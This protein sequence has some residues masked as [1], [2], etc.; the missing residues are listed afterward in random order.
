M[1]A[2]LPQ[3]APVHSHLYRTPVFGAEFDLLLACVHSFDKQIRDAIEQAITRNVNWDLFAHM[4]GHHG[5]LPSVFQQLLAHSTDVPKSALESFKRLHQINS[6]KTLWLTSELLRVAEQFEQHG[7]NFLAYKG[8]TLGQFL[9]GDVTERQFGDLDLLVHPSDV[10]RAISLVRELG[11]RSNLALNPAQAKA[12]LSIGY[13]YSFDSDF[14]RN[15]LEIKWQ[16]LPCFYAI[17]FDVDKLFLRAT[18]IKISEQE[19]PTLGPEDLLLVLCVH[20]A[21][22][23][24]E[25]LSWLWDMAA[26]T[27]RVSPDWDAIQQQARKLGIERILA[28]NFL[29]AN[30]FLKAP[31][32]G[33]MLPYI[34]KDK[35]TDLFAGK[36]APMMVTCKN[37]DVASKSYF[38]EF[39]GLRERAQNRWKF[40][41]RLL[42][43]PNISEW[44]TA[45]LA[46]P[47][48]PI[49]HGIRFY[50]LATKLIRN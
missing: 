25:K 21:K 26:L 33:T 32:P 18:S 30:K 28:I 31:V 22:H 27:Q 46:N 37:C 2:A 42:T 47:R 5:V 16:V 12:Y 24:W 34:E 17:D 7:I 41:W 38:R 44:K 39:A 10:A 35:K 19:I 6:R 43:T 15:L 20:A 8:P 11:Y 3:L 50:R 13:E 29:L 45:K 36:I 40:W 48:S 9:Y 49:Y 1:A 23:G 14:G 4:A